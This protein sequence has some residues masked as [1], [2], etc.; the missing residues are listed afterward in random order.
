MATLPQSG[1]GAQR[2][3]KETAGGEPGVEEAWGG[4][5]QGLS[6]CADPGGGYIKAQPKKPP[7]PDIFDTFAGDDAELLEALRA[8]E[9]MRKTIKKPMTER[10]KEL[11]VRKLEAEF[12]RDE[13]IAIL[14]Q[15]T[16]NCWQGIFPLKADGG[17]GGRSGGE[18]GTG[19]PFFDALREGG[20]DIQ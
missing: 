13:W 11:L 20:Y 9:K 7:K 5:A 18:N 4:A 1:A 12:L 3:Q 10:A 6:P 19:N 16:M 17:S 15:S 2:K 14:N 8:F